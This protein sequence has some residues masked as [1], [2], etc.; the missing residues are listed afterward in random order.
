[1]SGGFRSKR[2]A[3]TGWLLM[4]ISLVIGAT[5][6]QSLRAE[7]VVGV[8]PTKPQD[9]G[10]QLTVLSEQVGG[11]GFHPLKLRFVP[12]GASFTRQR[13]LRI[14]LRPRTTYQ[15]RL[16]YQYAVDV[17]VP[18]GV[19]A[20]QVDVNVPSYYRW[21]WI[22]I[23]I[24][25]DGR[26]THRRASRT[27][28]PQPVQY[29]GQ[30]Q[31]IGVVIPL[32]ARLQNGVWERFPDLRALSSVIGND[33]IP[34]NKKADRLTDQDAF[35]FASQL[36]SGRLRFRIQQEASLRDDWLAY[37]QLDTLILPCSVLLRLER[38]RPKILRA[39]QKWV[40]AGGQIWTYDLPAD[41]FE[42]GHWLAT[43]NDVDATNY[44]GDFTNAMEL[45]SKNIEHN[46]VY[47]EYSGSFYYNETIV[48]ANRNRGDFYKD[49]EDANSP[50]AK[51]LD[52]DELKQLV[53][54]FPYGFGRVALIDQADPFP[55]SFHLWLALKQSGRSWHQ[56]QGVNISSGS[57]SYWRWLISTVGQPPV[58]I[59]VLLNGV[60]VIVMGPVLYF[61]LRRRGKLHWLYFLAPTLAFLVTGCLFLYAFLSDGLSNRAKVR[62]L[63]WIDARSPSVSADPDFAAGIASQA[64]HYPAVDQ[65]RHTYYTIADSKKGL[66]FPIDSMVLPVS[67]Y[68]IITGYTYRTSDQESSGDYLIEQLPESRRFYG[69]FLST[70]SQTEFL[71]TQPSFQ[72]LPIKIDSSGNVPTV[73]NQLDEPLEAIAYRDDRG[74][75]W[76]AYK[77]S[78]GQ[79]TTFERAEPN[80]LGT[81]L[82]DR[83]EPDANRVPAAFRNFFSDSSRTGLEQKVAELNRRSTTKAFVAI[84]AID[85]ERFALDDCVQEGCVR[86]I[87][88]LLP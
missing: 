84:T 81:V 63:T 70:R 64:D 80:I 59:F 71:E 79:T 86:V 6:S 46:Y 25:E 43:P 10:F 48:S 22:A 77:L 15:T 39:I 50:M 26:R 72:S 23:V 14:L 37:S 17:V 1:M 20:H 24:E 69:S 74:G 5:P 18:E 47:Q 45:N 58:S 11:D 57:E 36:D 13:N 85:P 16:D 33:S 28:I 32:D 30:Q 62:Q 76:V 82:R 67:N 53:R 51:K 38:E 73:T 19:T 7:I 83:L 65:L 88:G 12:L 27:S 60:F 34:R 54:A 29:W 4:V 61:V 40:A 66:H 56:R 75:Y 55:G 68:E 2:T 78:A 3:V 52:R 44:V 41:G 8:A 31:S 42:A 9:V 49:L 87:A 21:D 35:N